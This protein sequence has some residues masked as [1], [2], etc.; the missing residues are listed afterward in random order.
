MGDCPSESGAKARP[1][2]RWIATLPDGDV[3]AKTPSTAWRLA[4]RGRI[5]VLCEHRGERGV[6]EHVYFEYLRRNRAGQAAGGTAIVHPVRDCKS[7]LSLAHH[8][9]NVLQSQTSQLQ[10]AIDF[11]TQNIR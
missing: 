11:S 10:T 4:A 2:P 5:S 3:I 6:D 9:E 8:F 1:L 7:T